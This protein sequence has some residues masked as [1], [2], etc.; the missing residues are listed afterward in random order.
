MAGQISR[1]YLEIQVGVEDVRRRVNKVLKVLMT[2]SNKSSQEPDNQEPFVTVPVPLQISLSPSADQTAETPSLE[3]PTE[4]KSINHFWGLIYR[5]ND[6]LDR[7]EEGFNKL[8]NGWDKV[9][10]EL[11]AVGITGVDQS[12]N[13]EANQ[14]WSSYVKQTLMVKQLYSAVEIPEHTTRQN[15]QAYVATSAEGQDTDASVQDVSVNLSDMAQHVAKVL[16]S[17]SL[18]LLLL[19]SRNPN[20]VLLR[21]FTR[22]LALCTAQNPLDKLP[23]TYQT[24]IPLAKTT[25]EKCHDTLANFR[26][27]RTQVKAIAGASNLFQGI[28]ENNPVASIPGIPSHFQD[29]YYSIYQ[30]ASW[31]TELD[32]QAGCLLAELGNNQTS[33]RLRSTIRYWTKLKDDSVN[34]QE[35]PAQHGSLAYLR[36]HICCC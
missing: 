18:S 17:P 9:N 11:E 21:S 33:L 2:H 30:L 36:N 23:K 16:E 20:N 22:S 5:V 19:M 24:V 10:L 8:Q 12:H 25:K 15:L 7:I 3:R 35:L 29:L 1:Q 34:Y 28:Q 13:A 31:W 27:M 32:M 4:G 14:L 26:V 6:L